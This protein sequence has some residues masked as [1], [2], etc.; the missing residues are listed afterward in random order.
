ME[1][2]MQTELTALKKRLYQDNQVRNVKF[3]PGSSRDVSSEDLAREIN[4]FFA[5]P[6]TKDEK[7]E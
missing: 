4:K 5:D 7:C 6:P 1:V 2:M 3:Y